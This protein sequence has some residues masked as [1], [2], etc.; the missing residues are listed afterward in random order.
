MLNAFCQETIVAF[1][2]HFAGHS[3]TENFTMHN[4]NA[5]CYFKNG[6]H[7]ESIAL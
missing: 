6:Y 1:L 3:P 5:E 2:Q 7:A 4:G